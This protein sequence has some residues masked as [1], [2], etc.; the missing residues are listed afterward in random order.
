MKIKHQFLHKYLWKHSGCTIKQ[1]QS[2]LRIKGDNIGDDVGYVAR[3][4]L[5]DLTD[6]SKVF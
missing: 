4:K 1:I 3:V 6:Y 5:E 2:G